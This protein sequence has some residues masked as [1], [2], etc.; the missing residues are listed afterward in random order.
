MSA[1][2][3]QILIVIF[4]LVANSLWLQSI[5]Y[6]LSDVAEVLKKWEKT[7]KEE[8]EELE[9]ALEGKQR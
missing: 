3:I 8:K 6:M 2:S 7:L 4:L 9:K 1:V 5:S